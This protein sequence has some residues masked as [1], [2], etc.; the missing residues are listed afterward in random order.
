MVEPLGTSS[1]ASDQL[2]QVALVHRNQEHPNRRS[3]PDTLRA[4]FKGG[5]SMMIDVRAAMKKPPSP[6]WVTRLLAAP[7]H[8]LVCG[9]TP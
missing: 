3:S 8:S 7:R 9:G 4:S 2:P 5:L 1:W 6:R